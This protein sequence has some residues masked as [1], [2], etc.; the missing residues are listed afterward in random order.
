MKSMYS[1]KCDGK[2]YKLLPFY[3]LNYYKNQMMLK[4]T[5]LCTKI[6]FR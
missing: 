2:T 6:T 3:F 1:L 5:A 4:F